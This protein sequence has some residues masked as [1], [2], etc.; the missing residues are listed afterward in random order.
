MAL[1]VHAHA[2]P[3]TDATVRLYNYQPPKGLMPL[4]M[5]KDVFWFATVLREPRARLISHHAHHNRNL[6]LQR[7]QRSAKRVPTKIGSRPGPESPPEP[8]LNAQGGEEIISWIN[9]IPDNWMTRQLCGRYCH[10]VPRGQLN[11]SHVN[12]ARD[13]LDRFD[14][15]LVLEAFD[16]S[17]ALL[18]HGQ[19]K[20]FESSSG[21]I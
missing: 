13:M 5:N 14:A 10:G 21:Y 4:E 7:K 16:E 12:R 9:H 19:C 1:V 3:N 18:R 11:L 20:L 2:P 17:A 15:V 6:M 8:S